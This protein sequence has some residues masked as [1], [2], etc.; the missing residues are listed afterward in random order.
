M[1]ADIQVIIADLQKKLGEQEK[2]VI[3]T[4]ELINDLLSHYGIPTIY[5]DA[6]LSPSSGAIRFASDEFYGQPLAGSMRKILQH[7]KAAQLGP[8]TPREIYEKLVAGGYAFESDNEQNRLIGIR[9]SLRK[10]SA[11]FHRLPDGKR[12]GLLD[13]YPK[14]KKSKTK[15]LKESDEPMPE[16]DRVSDQ[17]DEQPDEYNFEDPF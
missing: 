14:A 8:A 15:E 16:D 11:I 17:E 3:R 1:S 9:V 12:Y 4:K 13:W 7:R 6:E 2:E 10:S 5:K